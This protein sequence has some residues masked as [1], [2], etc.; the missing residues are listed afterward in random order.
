MFTNIQRNY[1]RLVKPF[2]RLLSSSLPS[3]QTSITSSLDWDIF[4][5]LHSVDPYKAQ[6]YMISGIKAIEL[7]V[8]SNEIISKD[9]DVIIKS[10]RDTIDLLSEEAISK[11]ISKDKDETIKSMR[12]KIDLLSKEAISKEISKCKDEAIK[13]KD[14][15]IKCK[16]EVIKSMRD[17]IDLLTEEAIDKEL[18]FHQ[19]RGRVNLRGMFEMLLWICVSENPSNR[20]MQTITTQQIDHITSLRDSKCQGQ[21]TRKLL[22]TMEELDCD[23]HDFDSLLCENM[24]W[25]QRSVRIFTE[26][27]LQERHRLLAERIVGIL[28][29]SVPPEVKTGNSPT[30]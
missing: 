18:K 3:S 15:A 17:T 25:N 9:K 5:T 2:A 20:E 13:C 16:D 21:Y 12:D 30:K 6:Q 14:E 23:L 24:P 10:M 22:T 11:E 26:K 27:G 19:L 28:D 8:K 4:Q 7:I 29:S 1:K